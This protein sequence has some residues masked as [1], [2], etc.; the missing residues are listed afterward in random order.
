MPHVHHRHRPQGRRLALAAGVAGLLA[1]I[2]LLILPP[3]AKANF[4]YWASAGQTTVGRA[5]LNGTGVNNAFVTGLTNVHGVAVDDPS[6]PW[7]AT[8]PVVVSV[9]ARRFAR[10]LP[11][12]RG[13]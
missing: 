13:G 3:L 8:V 1:T 6:M 2:V 7:T 12:E 10:I 11:N 9:G 5:K 4:V